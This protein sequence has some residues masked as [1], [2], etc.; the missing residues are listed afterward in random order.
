MADIFVES[1][2]PGITLSVRDECSSAPS[3][4]V[5]VSTSFGTAQLRVPVSQGQPIYV[6]VES[7]DAGVASGFDLVAS[8][9]P[10]ACGDGYVDAGE[11]CDDGNF[12]DDDGCDLECNFQSSEDNPNGSLN[13]ADP[14]QP[15]AYYGSVSSEN[16]R[17]TVSIDVPAGY[18]L[19]A[20]TSDLGD[21]A[22]SQLQMDTFLELFDD[23]GDLV[24]DDD[25]S[26]IGFCAALV[27]PGLPE[28]E[29][30]VRLTGSGGS[31]DFFYRLEIELFAP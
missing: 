15:P 4:R 18:M 19:V 5:C 21:G 22:C 25:D 30:F 24:A 28:G 1:G 6:L 23:A 11:E 27:A 10:I 31:S 9:R 16:D 12:N 7:L 2:A 14:Y 26:G 29:Y 20:Q 13:Q 3:E 17:D 8:A